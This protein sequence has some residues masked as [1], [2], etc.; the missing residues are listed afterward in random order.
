MPHCQHFYHKVMMYLD[1]S[2]LQ[3]NRF[4]WQRNMPDLRRQISDATPY[5]PRPNFL[6]LHAVF[7]KVAQNNRLV[8]SLRSWRPHGKSW[9]RHCM[10]RRASR[11]IHCGGRKFS[12]ISP[13][14]SL[15]EIESRKVFLIKGWARP[16]KIM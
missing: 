4:N 16:A 7:K 6:H 3:Q 10:Q 2:V 1:F 12:R 5:T 8:P 14:F 11:I 13:K 15:F 9:I